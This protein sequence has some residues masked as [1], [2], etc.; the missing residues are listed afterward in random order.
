MWSLNVHLSKLISKI[1][2]F[3][4]VCPHVSKAHIFLV[5][6]ILYHD[7]FCLN[8]PENHLASIWNR[9]DKFLALAEPSKQK[10]AQDKK[11]TVK[12]GKMLSTLSIRFFIVTRGA[13]SSPNRVG[14]QFYD[15][16]PNGG[17]Y[18]DWNENFSPASFTPSLIRWGTICRKPPGNISA[19]L[20]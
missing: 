11:V 13:Q 9:R 15:D 8:R 3:K 2:N 5:S 4:N 19:T 12:N 7:F 6:F 18:M 14:N 10:K 1:V 17:C 20:F 16:K